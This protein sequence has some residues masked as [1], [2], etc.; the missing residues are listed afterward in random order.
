M[1]Y[2][3]GRVTAVHHHSGCWEVV[4]EGEHPGAFPIDNVFVWPIVD[5]EGVDWI[6]RKV[7]YADGMMRFLDAAPACPDPELASAPCRQHFA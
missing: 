4:V 2:C 3:K 5:T 6:G 1:S 7:E